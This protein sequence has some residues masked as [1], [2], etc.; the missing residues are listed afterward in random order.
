MITKQ[1]LKIK[2]LSVFDEQ[3]QEIS[4][5]DVHKETKQSAGW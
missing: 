2:D 4:L 5:A 1:K 3:G